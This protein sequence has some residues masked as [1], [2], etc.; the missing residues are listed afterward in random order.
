MSEHEQPRSPF[1]VRPSR[2][3][4]GGLLAV[5]AAVLGLA[6]GG[7]ALARSEEAATSGGP[8]ASSN[9]NRA[10]PAPPGTAAAGGSGPQRPDLENPFPNRTKAASLDGGTGWL[11]TA[12]EITLKDLRGKVVVLD[13]WTYCC[14]NCLH[15]L[16]DLKYLETKYANELVV[17]G[18]HS[19]K[20]DNEKDSENIRRAILRHG[21][22]HPVINDS[23]MDVWRKF[24]ARAWPTLV[25]I[26]PEGYYC[27]YVSGEGH[28]ELLEVVIK[29]LIAYHKAKG[30]LDE[31]PVR[32]Q[33]E[34]ESV[35]PTPLR[36]PAKILA[37]EKNDR[38]FV[39]DTGHNRIVVCTL[40]GKLL[41]VIGTGALGAKDGG[42][43]EATFDHPH[44][45]TLAGETLY[46]ADTENHLIR[47]VDLKSKT[48]STLA[49]T[50]EQD[51]L[52]S[53]GGRLRETPLNSPWDLLHVKGTLYICMAGPHQIWSHKLGT[54]IIGVY[55]GSGR[56]DVTNGPL[57]ASAF[58][59]PSGITTDGKF[60]YVADSEGSAIR[61]VPL[62]RGGTVGTVIGAND[63]PLGR[64]LFEF[65]DTDGTPARARLQHPLA[66]LYHENVLY[67]AD[68]YNHKI[69]KIE[70]TKG[71]VRART[72][73]GDG[74]RGDR[75]EPPR[76]AEPE[77]LAVAENKLYVAD[78]NNHRISTA[79]L[80]T[81][82][83]AV[84]EIA[85]LAPPKPP[86]P[87]PVASAG[88]T[89]SGQATRLPPQTVAPGESLRF[90]ITVRLPAGYKLNDL[91]P[92]NYRLRAEGEQDLI[93]AA[94]F[95]GRHKATAEGDV[96][97][98][99]VPLARPTG[100][101]TIE[102]AVSFGY[103]R[104]GVGGLCK[105]KTSRWLVPVEVSAE[106]K[107]KAIA[108]EST[109]EEKRAETGVSGDSLESGGNSG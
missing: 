88:G 4:H 96:I 31:T 29:K 6:A 59:Q 70:P 18:V 58:A 19:A 23:K 104:G 74:R 73:L 15:V 43:D 80:E 44:G 97:T 28:R 75:L 9:E 5:A 108:L 21:I 101:A 60:L 102:L 52:R 72:W 50:G 99:D 103:C 36:F 83:V 66:V 57:A 87:E 65:G 11:N 41:D 49:G 7:F 63:L 8:S 107:L 78:T 69:K 77:G 68:S 34:R 33:L 67:V 48:V 3:P 14:I 27:G 32:F 30:T 62:E 40:D 86:Q 91:A 76:F 84:L 55:A 10:A 38:L 39:A 20:F 64:A 100:K 106:G 54:N 98:V 89:A 51:R 12:G 93:A 47:A 42:Y 95:T 46:V 94:Q 82:K 81:G 79:D 56:E 1:P 26:D 25:V 2:S 37:D 109:P 53:G 24:G 16:P 45:M 71:G 13:F 90:R 22:E 17:V 61:R 105:L 35:E 85:G 92:L